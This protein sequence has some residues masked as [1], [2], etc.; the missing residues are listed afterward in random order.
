MGI[1]PSKESAVLQNHRGH[2]STRQRVASPSVRPARS[3]RPLGEKAPWPLTGTAELSVRESLL[4]GEDA[5][6]AA[7][8]ASG[9]W[10]RELRM[11]GADWQQRRGAPAEKGRWPFGLPGEASPFPEQRSA[12][13]GAPAWEDPALERREGEREG[14]GAR[15]A[16]CPWRCLSPR[17]HLAQGPVTVSEPAQ[18]ESRGSGA[19]ERVSGT[20]GASSPQAG[21]PAT[22]SSSATC[23]S[24]RSG[25]REVAIAASLSRRRDSL[26]GPRS[27]R[28][29]FCRDFFFRGALQRESGSRRRRSCC[30]FSRLGTGGHLPREAQPPQ[31][32]KV[33]RLPDLSEEDLLER[34]SSCHFALL[35]GETSLQV[36]HTPHRGGG[37]GPLTT[38]AQ[39]RRG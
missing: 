27:Y 28:H 39:R 6:A 21:P 37:P 18:P 2:K 22:V 11:A 15:Q 10:S 1:N 25:T 12:Q 16:G 5:A 17:R 9:S 38:S 14:A 32:L 36:Q 35:M 31:G 7:A 29:R 20:A 30:T 19:G 33:K 3:T 8:A 23:R 4:G 24:V 34:R 26:A 13:E